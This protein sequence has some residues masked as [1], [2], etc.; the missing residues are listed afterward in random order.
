MKKK[1]LICLITVLLAVITFTIIAIFFI[2]PADNPMEV[3][4]KPVIYLYP[5]KTTDVN[6]KLNYNGSLDYTYPS[7]NNGWSVT[8]DPSGKLINHADNREYSYLF[9]EGSSSTNYDFSTG[10]VVK[11]SDTVEFLQEKLAYM[12]L[13]PH[14]YNEFI[15]YWFPLIQD[16][17]YNLISFQGAV[18][19]DSAELV[20]T[21][22][23][24][25]LLRVFMAYKPLNKHV[26]IAEQVLEPFERKGFCVVEWGGAEVRN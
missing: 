2:S 12:G 17:N 19:T 26:E 7:Y 20:I 18:Y 5:Q 15:V 16:N 10:F 25:S 1:T 6:V 13:E 21:P 4:K 22:E 3:A 14:E 11:G 24:D 9:W 23:P 8:A